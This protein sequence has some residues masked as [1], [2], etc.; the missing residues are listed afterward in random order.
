MSTSTFPFVIVDVDGDGRVDM[1]TAQSSTLFVRLGLANAA[2]T[3]PSGSFSSSPTTYSLG[4]FPSQIIAGDITGDARP[5]LI[6]IGGS[7]SVD[8]MRNSGAGVFTRYSLTAS[9]PVST[10]LT[11]TSVTIGEFIGGAPA[12]ILFSFSTASGAQ[13]ATLWPGTGAAGSP[14][15]TG[16][17]AGLGIGTISNVR[18]ASVTAD[19]IPDL[20]ATAASNAIY[21][22]PGTGNPSPPFSTTLAVVAQLPSGESFT[23][24]VAG[25]S[26]AMDVGDVTAD[27]IP[28][29][30]VPV[31][32]GVTNGVRLFP[33]TAAP[34]FGTSTLLSTPSTVR[35]I[36]IADVNGDSRRDI[37]VAS[38]DIRIFLSQAGGT[39]SA[40]Q[41]LGIAFGA[42]FLNSLSVIDVTGDA[43]PEI[44]APS[45][46]AIITAVNNGTGGFGALQGFSVPNATRIAA[47]DLNGDGFS[48]VVATGPLQ[49]VYSGPDARLVD[50][51][52]N[53]GVVRGRLE[54]LV[55]GQ[56]GPVC[57]PS[58]PS[59]GTVTVACRS[60]GLGAAVS[61]YFATPSALAPVIRSP[62]CGDPLA[63]SVLTC[64]YY[65]PD[66]QC[67]GAN[68]LGIECQALTTSPLETNS[69]V[70]YGSATGTFTAGSVLTTRGD[71][72]L[73]GDLNGDSAQDLVVAA[74]SAADGGVSV[75][76]VRLGA[77]NNTLG[78]PVTLPL[79]ALPT[80]LVI[81]E[82]SNDSQQDLI[83]GSSAGVDVYRNL[84]GGTF[85]SPV[86][87]TTAVSSIAVADV[88]QDGR[89]DLVMGSTSFNRVQ[90]WFNVALPDSVGFAPGNSTNANF[91]N[92]DVLAADV[93]ADGKSDLIVGRNVYFGAGTGSFA[94]QTASL[95][96]LPPRQVLADL[97]N[98]GTLDLA[99]A[100]GA[101]SVVSI[102]PGLS[103]SAFGFS[104][105]PLGFSSGAVVEDIALGRTNSD[106]TRDLILLQGGF[107]ARSVVA[108][109]VVCR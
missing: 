90:P 99:A 12:D 25:S 22:Y 23:T 85:A 46:L 6:L 64:S 63:T 60:V 97:D 31:V 82:V 28:D 39:F 52:I 20:V 5:E 66:A 62:S 107:G 83:V 103:S 89:F 36:V 1:V 2:M 37:V 41:I 101:S 8:V 87:V 27:G 33:L 51:S 35:A 92:L 53:R 79:K 91:S 24:G 32:S 77:T 18:A 105:T 7:T 34:G 58:F 98:D 84:G 86:T 4:I 102:L 70:L 55:G 42:T 3:G 19:A 26:F 108:A 81:A 11:P 13:S 40:A 95:A 78:A 94:F 72:T 30:V 57:N 104:A 73:I 56:W 45:G 96:I 44:L 71:R 65:P 54:L 74:A 48:D 15:G 50:T 38:T 59:T 93:N 68:Q 17:S 9:S 29:V 100:G 75:L 88:N 49:N 61:P 69:Q 80:F 109:P 21:L 43:R 10:S 14:F 16:V 106:S 47:G 76:E 67:T